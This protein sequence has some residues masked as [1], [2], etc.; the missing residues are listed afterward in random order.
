[1][2]LTTIASKP[3]P[4]SIPLAAGLPL[5]GNVQELATDVA[6]FLT[7]QYKKLGPVF[8][9]RALNRELIVLAGLEA[10]LFYI[11]EGKALFRSKEFWQAQDAEFGAKS[12][13][14]SMDGEAHV[15]YRKVQRP[16]YA[17]S[18]LFGKLDRAITIAQTEM[19]T[20]PLQTP[21]PALYS[22]Q[23]II[24]EQLSIIA[25]NYSSKKD[26]DT[27]IAAVR[28][29]LATRVTQQRPAFLL[30]LPKFRKAKARLMQIEDEV[31]A[32][33]IPSL[34]QNET[35]DLIDALVALHT[36]DPQFLPR[37]D[38]ATAVLGPF[39]AGL[40]T[41][42]STSAFIL[43]ALLKYPDLA[44]R[45]TAEADLLFADS[46]PTEPKLRDLDVTH[47]VAM[48]AMR[49]WSI[50]PALTR[51]TTQA[52][53]FAGYQ[54]PAEAAVIIATT[55]PHHL[56]EYFP[57]PDKFDIDRYT[58]DRNE[59]RRQGAYAPFGLGPHI[60]LGQGLAEMQMALVIATLFHH[61]KLKL[62]PADY[63][64]G[65]DPVPTLSPDAKMKFEILEWRNPLST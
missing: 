52:F 3:K 6:G 44:E 30:Q 18:A 25:A 15:R 21:L 22:L 28:T 62:S 16:G 20:W 49:L 10:N 35:P 9:V 55:V 11:Q 23:R 13:L 27:I 26:L 1:M 63:E 33:H 14:I 12:S 8:R 65:L 36:E 64:L 58:P 43:Y 53:T 41:A 42:S 47:R 31:L 24:T 37:Q 61:A 54:I 57:N 51:T 29:I 38:M 2:T 17:R 46:G 4:S 5:L 59:H 32:N 48:E 50:A 39:I 56:D 19:A 40:D 7:K 45:V 60:C 34:R